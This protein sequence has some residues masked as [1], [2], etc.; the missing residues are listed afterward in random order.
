MHKRHYD[1]RDFEPR[2]GLLRQCTEEIAFERM[3]E[4][5][6]FAQRKNFGAATGPN[7]GGK[8]FSQYA[9]SRVCE[10]LDSQEQKREHH[11]SRQKGRRQR[12]NEIPVRV[13]VGFSGGCKRIL[14]C[15]IESRVVVPGVYNNNNVADG[16]RRARGLPHKR[17]Y[18]AVSRPVSLAEKNNAGRCS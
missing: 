3:N 15:V 10:K 13:P 11:Q 7:K 18:T 6:V 17:F 4:Y 16:A 2:R 1:K 5:R 9:V 8:H 14:L 12:N